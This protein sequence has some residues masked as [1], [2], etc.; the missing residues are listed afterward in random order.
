MVFIDICECIVYDVIIDNRL[1]VCCVSVHAEL[2]TC[3]SEL[4]MLH[5]SDGRNGL[6]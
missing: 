2:F 4:V 3:D 6:R 5:V 1:L